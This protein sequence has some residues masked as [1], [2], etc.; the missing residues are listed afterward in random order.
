MERDVD[1]DIFIGYYW[2]SL[3]TSKEKFFLVAVFKNEQ[4]ECY[5][6][7]FGDKA[8]YDPGSYEIF[9]KAEVR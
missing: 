5:A 9:I 6:L 3:C 7:E 2:A 4:N 8:V 1:K